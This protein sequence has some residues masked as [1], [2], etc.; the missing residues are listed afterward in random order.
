MPVY[1]Q[2]TIEPYND[3][4]KPIHAKHVGVGDDNKPL[5]D[6][7]ADL[8]EIPFFD[9]ATLG[10]P[11][12]SKDS[13][14]ILDMDTTTMR[15]ALD[16]GPV[17]FALNI[18]DHGRHEFVAN[19]LSTDV[20]HS[21][22]V[23]TS[24]GSIQLSFFENSLLVLLI[25]QDTLPAVTE[26]DNGKVLSVVGG[27]W[28]AAE[29]EAAAIPFFDLAE[30]GLPDVPSDGTAVD[31]ATDTTEIK[32][33][34][35][36]GSVKFAVNLEDAGRIEFV[37]N[38]YSID[39]YGLYA[40]IYSMPDSAIML[41]IADGSIQASIVLISTLPTV[42]ETDNGKIMRVTNG[43][44]SLATPTG[45]GTEIPTYDLAALGLADVEIGGEESTTLALDTSEIL[46]SLASGSVR[47]ILNLSFGG[48]VIPFNKI[49]NG[50]DFDEMVACTSC[51]YV[52]GID[53][54]TSIT[55]TQNAVVV[56]S[57]FRDDLILEVVDAYMEEA[58]GGDY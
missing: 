34:L 6:V 3:S 47:F 5:S 25:S 52:D 48:N 32:S 9:L 57:I 2:S 1:V 54:L 14:A 40:C 33:A 58:L 7:L 41:M 24:I 15:T 36:N 50:V 45:G 55:I 49:L 35:D 11:D 4:Y 27:A 43:V 21:C 53:L 10:L 12:I 46:A 22:F 39:A 13:P 29:Q 26:N 30:M 19:K 38:K 23:P 37:M 51:D 42:S 44:W 56:R 16:A 18:A 17:K 20:V 31:L 8:G 28:A